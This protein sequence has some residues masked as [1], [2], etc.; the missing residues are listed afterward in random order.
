MPIILV[1]LRRGVTNSPQY[2]SRISMIKPT[3]LLAMKGLG[4]LFVLAALFALVVAKEAGGDTAR[5]KDYT[6]RYAEIAAPVPAG[7]NV[8]KLVKILKEASRRNYDD[9]NIKN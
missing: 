1:I 6:A 4:I 5:N 9:L 7:V 3:R 8:E 2:K